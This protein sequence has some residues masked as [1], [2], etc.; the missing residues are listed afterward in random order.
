M[1]DMRE[2]SP[3]TWSLVRL[4]EF[5][6]S[7]KGK[8]PRMEQ[9]DQ[10]NLFNI[11][12]VDIEAFEQGVIKSWTNGE[13]CRLCDESDF[14]MVWDGSRSGLVGKGKKG[15]LGSTLVRINFPGI[16]NPYSFYFLQSK[17]LEIN[18]RAKGSGTPHVDPDLLWN[19]K[20]P[21]APLKEQTRIVAKIE[22]LFSE[23]DK[24]VEALTTAREQLNAYRQSVLKHAFDG[25]MTADLRPTHKAW[26]NIRL[27]DELEF[28]TS[29]SRGWA[30]FY[31]K[32]GDTFIR[33]QNLKYDRLDLTDIAYVKL[34]EGNTEGIRTRVQVGDVLVTITGANVTKT[35]IVDSDMGAAYVSQHVALCRPRPSIRSRFLYWYLLSEAH[36]RRQLNEAA[37]GAGKPGL[38]LDNIKSV[39]ISLPSPQEQAIVVER[40]EAALSVEQSFSESIDAELQR[41]NALRQSVLKQAFSGHLVSQDPTDEPASELLKRIRTERAKASASKPGRKTKKIRKEKET[42][43]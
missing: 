15:A 31:A 1:S 34:P 33:A 3:S 18:S 29:G 14:L 6:E 2:E 25:K 16:Y 7:E 9:K 43:R 12:Y 4:G 42:A 27:G 26:R 23:L 5:V 40:I 19:Y 13:E 32:S 22:E 30:E 37:Y 39:A 28:L 8:K 36:G 17:F 35:G 21:V 10:D 38:N 41:T 20:F 24:G 11:P